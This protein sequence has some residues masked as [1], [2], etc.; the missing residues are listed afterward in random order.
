[1]TARFA[2]GD[3]VRSTKYPTLTNGH[4]IELDGDLVS[5]RWADASVRQWWP[6]DELAPI[7]PGRAAHAASEPE[8]IKLIADPNVRPGLLMAI[9]R[10]MTGGYVFVMNPLHW[11]QWAKLEPGQVAGPYVSKEQPS[12]DDPAT[13]TWGRIRELVEKESRLERRANELSDKCGALETEKRDLLCENA[14]LRRRVEVLERD[15]KR[16]RR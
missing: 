9:P 8:H 6:T 10:K 15:G 2:V 12:D 11:S 13:T 3:W 4:V 5:V 16:G 14:T 7:E 1:M